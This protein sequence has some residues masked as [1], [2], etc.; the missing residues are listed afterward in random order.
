MSEKQSLKPV[1]AFLLLSSWPIRASTLLVPTDLP[2]IQACIDAAISGVDECVVAPGTY[3]EKIDFIGKAITLRSSNGADV[4]TIDAT[5]L[6]G[7]VVSCVT[8]EGPGTVLQGFAITG[9]TGI[10]PNGRWDG[11]GMYNSGASPTVRACKFHGNTAQTGGGMYN[12]AHSSPTVVD[13]LFTGNSAEV[14]GAIGNFDHGT[15]TVT[16]CVFR[17]NSSVVGGAIDN[18]FNSSATYTNCTL[19]AN[20]ATS[21]GGGMCN[22]NNSNATVVNC[23]FIGNTAG[24]NGGGMDNYNSDPIIRNCVFSANTAL[25][26]GGI[27]NDFLSTPTITHCTI[28]DNIAIIGGGIFSDDSDA[29]VSNSVLWGNSPTQFNRADGSPPAVRF[30]DV[31]GILPVGVLDA[32]GNIHLDPKPV[33][34][35]TPGADGTWGGA[36]DDYGDLRLQAGSPCIDAGDPG[37]VPQPGATDLDGHTRVLGGRVD[38]GAYEFGIGDHDGNERVNLDD[39]AAWP[40]CISAPTNEPLAPNC[41]VFDF[42]GDGAVDLTDFSAF[43]RS[44][45]HRFVVFTDPV[46]SI[47]FVDVNDV[48]GEIVRFDPFSK[49]I[50]WAATDT[51]YNAGFWPVNG[52]FL[53]SGFFS[54]RYGTSNGVRRAYFTETVAATI[55]DIRIVGSQMQIFA[56]NVH[57]P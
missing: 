1:I 9:G 50:V 3:H 17:M 45:T 4:T 32:G 14:G 19:I 56:T 35:P 43:Q 37:F 33:R 36:D 34:L 29:T 44:L 11:G 15:P 47:Q 5:G 8:G 26:G 20:T 28:L 18:C 30:S 49:A 52:N 2:S 48:Q 25:F 21:D 57:V 7:S 41:A 22:T 16:N 10:V 13:C 53:G 54:V 24:A 40:S 38:M 51:P 27:A 46:T 6:G 39:F 42:H 31:Q 23:S 55:C 12:A